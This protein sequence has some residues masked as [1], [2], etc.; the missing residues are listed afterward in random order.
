MSLPCL[1]YPFRIRK[2]QDD[3]QALIDSGSEVNTMHPA[4]AAK[5]GLPVGKTD[6]GTQ[7]IDKS[8]LQ[9]GHSRLLALGQT[10]KCSILPGD[11][12]VG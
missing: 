4:Y 10:G 5:L 1:R 9:D 7:K 2:D 6:V 12:F 8:H 11:L 3:T